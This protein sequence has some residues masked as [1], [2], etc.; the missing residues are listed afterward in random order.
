MTRDELRPVR[1]Q[2]ELLKPQLVLDERGI[3][4]TIVM[5]GRARIPA[6]E[7]RDGASPDSRRAVALLRRGPPLRPR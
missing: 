1:L 6:P 5:F 2:L 7:H 4:S 3:N